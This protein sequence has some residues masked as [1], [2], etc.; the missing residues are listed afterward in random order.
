MGKSN[1][2][3]YVMWFVALF[4][5][6]P[7]VNRIIAQQLQAIDNRLKI[8]SIIKRVPSGAFLLPSHLKSFHYDE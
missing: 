4:V 2:V 7:R 8:P 3:V 6:D 5:A 1:T